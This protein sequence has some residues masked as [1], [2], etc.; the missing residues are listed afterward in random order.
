MNKEKF[1]QKA[2]NMFNNLLDELYP[3]N[4]SCFCCDEELNANT[5]LC[6]NCLDDLKPIKYFCKRCGEKVNSFDN[7]C[8]ICKTKQYNF[9]KC[10][11]CFEYDGVAKKL[12]YKL[13][14]GGAKYVSK[15]FSKNL[16]E[17]FL[18]A[19]F[20]NIDLLTC[21]P[22]NKTRLKQRGYNQAEVLAKDFALEANK[23]NINFDCDFNLITRIKNTPT[24]THLTR[25]ERS[26]NLKEAFKINCDKNFLKGKN[27]LVVDDIFTTGATMD[28]IA[29]V[30]KKS[31]A[32]AVFGLTVCHTILEKI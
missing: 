29:K 15:A 7:F 4:L 5:Y 16:L 9:D 23:N 20:E 21:A 8:L 10:I 27:I 6:K 13:K 25:K 24:Q 1:K 32:K 14:Y 31:G 30:L 17:K 18:E 28:E 2:L 19:K 3:E 11:A 26:E 22:L 12:I